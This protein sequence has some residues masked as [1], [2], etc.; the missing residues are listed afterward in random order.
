MTAK[1]LLQILKSVD[2]E[3]EVKIDA[4]DGVLN[5]PLLPI[6]EVRIRNGISP[7]ILLTTNL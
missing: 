4:F 2:P 5:E 6:I 3:A 1:Q 7:V